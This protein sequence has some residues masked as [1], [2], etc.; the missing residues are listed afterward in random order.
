MIDENAI[1]RDLERGERH[2]GREAFHK[3]AK[4]IPA[5]RTVGRNIEGLTKEFGRRCG[6]KEDSVEKWAKAWRL[7]KVIRFVCIRYRADTY[8][9]KIYRREFSVSHFTVMWE[10]GHKYSLSVDKIM[11]YFDNLLVSGYFGGSWSV[12]TLR[13]EVEADHEHA[14]VDWRRWHWP[15]LITMLETLV[16]FDGE[17][18]DEVKAWVKQGL[19]LKDKVK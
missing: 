7:Y 19:A 9:M 12:E 13:R 4:S 3:W 5:S 1:E 16:T 18:G 10:L 17:L 8:R 11:E 14:A 15:R 2:N 6:V